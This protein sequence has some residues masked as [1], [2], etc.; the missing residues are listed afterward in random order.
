VEKKDDSALGWLAPV[1]EELLR[2]ARL[3]DDSHLL[4]V[5]AGTGLSAAA[6]VHNGK[7]T[8]TD[9]SEGMLRIDA[10]NVT[11]RGIT[12]LDTWQCEAGSMPFDDDSFDA[13]TCRY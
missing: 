6:I 9:L 7:V 11:R 3:N 12:N 10:E 8:I 1:G 5:A 4:D 2:S 13:F